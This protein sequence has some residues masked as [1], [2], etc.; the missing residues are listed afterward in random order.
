MP[1]IK[2]KVRIHFELENDLIVYVLNTRPRFE[3]LVSE[4]AYM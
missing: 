4:Q 1:A 3:K 2:T